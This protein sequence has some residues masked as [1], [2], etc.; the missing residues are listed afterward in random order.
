MTK[1]FFLAPQGDDSDDDGGLEKKPGQRAPA[2]VTP[3]E[4][5]AV[6]PSEPTAVTP[7]EPP[8]VT[9]GEQEPPS[10]KRGRP[11]I[12]DV[13]RDPVTGRRIRPKAEKPSQRLLDHLKK[14]REVKKE[15]D[16]Q[17]K[18]IHATAKD[19]ARKVG[20]PKVQLIELQEE[21]TMLRKQLEECKAAMAAAK[22]AEEYAPPPPPLVVAKKQPAKGGK[23]RKYESSSE[24]SSSDDSSDDDSACSDD[25]G[26]CHGRPRQ[27]VFFY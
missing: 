26:L 3:S 8:T 21:A 1:S 10:K 25:D 13:P 11:P 5:I 2:A 22:P 17:R 24:E 20:I 18:E 27:S 14:A 12:P 4:P 19:L 7:S 15:Y 9:P 23:K 6:P 16:A